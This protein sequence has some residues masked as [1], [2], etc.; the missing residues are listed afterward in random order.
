MSNDS[1]PPTV[2]RSP[3]VTVIVFAGFSWLTAVAEMGWC[4]GT[5]LAG[6]TTA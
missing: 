3:A 4:S 1:D 2:R 5:W 6:T